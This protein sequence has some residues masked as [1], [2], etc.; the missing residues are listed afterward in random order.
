M[1]SMLACFIENLREVLAE[2][3]KS[4]FLFNAN[5]LCFFRRLFEVRIAERKALVLL[6]YGFRGVHSLLSFIISKDEVLMR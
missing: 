5:F 2:R 1:T 4:V 6:G 3:N